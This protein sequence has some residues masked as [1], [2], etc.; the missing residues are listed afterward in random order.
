MSGFTESTE[1]APSSSRGVTQSDRLRTNAFSSGWRRE[2]RGDV[3]PVGERRSGQPPRRGLVWRWVGRARRPV[4]AE[5]LAGSAVHCEMNCR[6]IA[7]TLAGSVLWAKW[8]C[9]SSTRI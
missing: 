1:F 7:E 5:S 9:P 8:A 2:G 4:F 3:C 6:M